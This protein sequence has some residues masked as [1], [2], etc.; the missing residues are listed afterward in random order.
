MLTALKIQN[1]AL[2][3]ELDIAFQNGLNIIT[4]ETGAGKSIILGALGLILGNRADV[5]ALLDRD[6]K[7]VIEGRFNIAGYPFE[8]FFKNN[9][10]D[11]EENSLI[12]REI[13]PG[14]K[15]RAFINDTPVNLTILKEF[16]E[17]LVDIH[18]QDQ[19]RQLSDRGFQLSL[20][21]SLAG[22]KKSI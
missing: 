18:S 9:D 22:H 17:K 10:L 15:S 20:L 7:C 3:Q 11:W 5:D 14:G 2:I 4:G 13:S 6:I 19:T 16:G 21:D 12:R 1:Y 8:D